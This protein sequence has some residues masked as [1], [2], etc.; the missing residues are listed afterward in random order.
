MR[1]WETTYTTIGNTCVWA[2]ILERHVAS[3]QWELQSC[4]V[5]KTSHSKKVFVPEG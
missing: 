4:L 3:E 1:A 5:L 2:G